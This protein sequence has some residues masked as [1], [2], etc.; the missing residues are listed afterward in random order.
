MLKEIFAELGLG[1]T[2]TEADVLTGVSGLKAKLKEFASVFSELGLG[3]EA[4]VSH[5]LDAIKRLKTDLESGK[6]ITVKFT[7]METKVKKLERDARISFYRDALIPLKTLSGKPEDR[8]IILVELEAND[9]KLAET[10]LKEYKDTHERLVAAG[11][12]THQGAGGGGDNHNEEEHE[13]EKEVKKYSAEKHV[14]SDDAMV[15]M[16]KANP[17]LWREY[18]K[19]KRGAVLVDNNSSEDGGD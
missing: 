1:E 9:L 11:V 5:A 2:A 18:R 19:S 17:A 14:S 6:V 16:R 3:A 10:M 7:D 12:L 4:Q 8:A 15:A 13:F